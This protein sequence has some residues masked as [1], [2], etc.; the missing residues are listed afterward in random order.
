MA[1]PHPSAVI[2]LYDRPPRPISQISRTFLALRRS[3]DPWS[4]CFSVTARS[5]RRCSVGCTK[6]GKAQLAVVL[7]FW[8]RSRPC[9]VNV[10]QRVSSG[11]TERKG[12]EDCVESC[13]TSRWL[14]KRLQVCSSGF[15]MKGPCPSPTRHLLS[16]RP[17]YINLN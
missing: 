15:T 10:E 6:K 5:L 13:H 7:K 17:Q 4:R 11:Y 14:R 1:H 16:S 8:I 9:T 2:L 3:V 12:Y